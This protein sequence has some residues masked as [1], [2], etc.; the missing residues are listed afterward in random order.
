MTKA[1]IGANVKRLRESRNWS[2]EKLAAEAHISLQ[3]VIRVEGGKSKPSFE[4]LV[5]IANAFD[6][7]LDTLV[8][9]AKNEG[10]S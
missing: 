7:C 8:G 2:R 3:T 4:N 6:V 10:V 5:G 9:R 1:E